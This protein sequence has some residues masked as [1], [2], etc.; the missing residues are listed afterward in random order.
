M[1][2]ARLAGGMFVFV[3]LGFLAMATMLRLR[4]AGDF[5]ETARRINATNDGSAHR[6]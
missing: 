3:A 2:Y 4:V 5:L 1:R 6:D